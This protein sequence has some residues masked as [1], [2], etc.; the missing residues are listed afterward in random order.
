MLVIFI[1]RTM[2]YLSRTCACDVHR[3]YYDV[4]DDEGAF[5]SSVY[6]LRVASSWDATRREG[7]VP[8][9]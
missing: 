3:S 6:E 5:A 2:L 9:A 1:G 7:M 4:G 8:C